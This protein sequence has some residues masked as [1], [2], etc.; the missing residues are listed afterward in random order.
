MEDL[1]KKLFGLIL[2]ALLS[3]NSYVNSVSYNNI[4]HA[5]ENSNADFINKNLSKIRAL[6]KSEKLNLISHAEG[7]QKLREKDLKLDKTKPLVDGRGAFLLA[8]GILGGY[9]AY[10]LALGLAYKYSLGDSNKFIELSGISLASFTG[11]GIFYLLHKYDNDKG[12][13]FRTRKQIYVD[14]I[15]TKKLLESL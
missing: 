1:V 8:S 4:E 9:G 11:S 5:I 7:T 14:A 15:K 3:A 13:I 10:M 12:Y 6:S 2:V